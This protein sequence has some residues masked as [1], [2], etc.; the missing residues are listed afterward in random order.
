MRMMD[1]SFVVHVS[2]LS[3]K[4]EAIKVASSVGLATI[5]HCDDYCISAEK[6]Q[7]LP[8]VV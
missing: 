8:S 4:H 5:F 2:P 6:I 1:K 7:E 3:Y